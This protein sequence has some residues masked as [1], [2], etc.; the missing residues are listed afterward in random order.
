MLDTANLI[1]DYVRV[2]P[3]IEDAKAV[4]LFWILFYASLLTLLSIIA[5]LRLCYLQHLRP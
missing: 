2:M 1:F 4:A 5:P 3:A